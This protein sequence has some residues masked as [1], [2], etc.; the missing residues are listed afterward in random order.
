MIA[1]MDEVEEQVLAELEAALS[2][3]FPSMTLSNAVMVLAC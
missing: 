1:A 3:C 2:H